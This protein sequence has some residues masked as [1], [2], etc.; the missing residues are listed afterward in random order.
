[1]K[2]KETKY[3]EI[4]EVPLESAEKEN[5]TPLS[6]ASRGRTA[7]LITPTESLMMEF[8]RTRKCRVSRML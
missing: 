7:P 3:E 5:P 6:L 4:E 2:E 8:A 1:M